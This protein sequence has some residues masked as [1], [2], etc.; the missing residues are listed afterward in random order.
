MIKDTKIIKAC[1]SCP[2]CSLSMDGDICTHP[3][4]PK[5]SY[6]NLIGRERGVY[7]DCP[8]RN[9]SLVVTYTLV[10]K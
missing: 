5:G 6:D 2:M 9:T 1:S 3:S 7:K 4:W 8:L 10:E